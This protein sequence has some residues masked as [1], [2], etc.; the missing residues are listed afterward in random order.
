MRQLRAMLLLATSGLLPL[1]SS[2][3]EPEDCPKTIANISQEPITAATLNT[4]QQ[5]Y[6][7]LGCL[8]KFVTLPGRRSILHFNKGLVDGE[9]FRLKLVEKAYQR[10]FVRSSPPLFTLYNSLWLHPD[11]S[12]SEKYPH[13]YVIGIVWQERYMKNRNGILFHS[14]EKMYETYRNGR[15]GGFLGTHHSVKAQIASGRLPIAPILGKVI[16][17]EPLY[18]YLGSEYAPFMQRFSALIKEKDP[19][20][21]IGHPPK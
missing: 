6:V 13:G 21:F 1:H 11:P 14:V 9:F 7:D 17:A 2:A 4:F 15:L 5:I 16:M 8:T 18:H 12:I 10:E 3:Q 20:S 19:F